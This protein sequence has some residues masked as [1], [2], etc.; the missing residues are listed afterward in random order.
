M[1]SLLERAKLLMRDGIERNL[2]LAKARDSFQD[3][4]TTLTEARICVNCKDRYSLSEEGFYYPCKS[5]PGRIIEYPKRRWSCCGANPD[6]MR[7]HQR[8]GCV[9]S[10]HWDGC[11]DCKKTGGHDS[12]SCL[13]VP[14][15][16]VFAMNGWQRIVRS[17]EQIKDVV[18]SQYQEEEEEEEYSHYANPPDNVWTRGDVLKRLLDDSTKGTKKDDAIFEGHLSVKIKRCKNICHKNGSFLLYSY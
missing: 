1:N 8:Q 10:H 5:H 15:P 16:L 2:Y 17:T 7:P 6:K 4:Y 3:V 9:D 12:E 11:D 18:E 13:M 14:L